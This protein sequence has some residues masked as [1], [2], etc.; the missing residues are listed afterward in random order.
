[1]DRSCHHSQQIKADGVGQLSL[2]FLICG[3]WILR[4]TKVGGNYWEG[5]RGEAVVAREGSRSE[6]ERSRLYTRTEISSGAH[7]LKLIQPKK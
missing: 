3:L 1:M 4:S 5:A 7:F 2:Y 6:Y